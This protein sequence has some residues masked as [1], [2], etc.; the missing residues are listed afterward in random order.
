[1]KDRKHTIISREPQKKKKKKKK[2]LWLLHDKDAPKL[3]I[4]G[5][6]LIKGIYEKPTTNMTLNGKNWLFSPLDQ[7]EDKNVHPWALSWWVCYKRP[8]ALWDWLDVRVTR[9]AKNIVKFL[10]VLQ[11][12]PKNTAYRKYTE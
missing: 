5:N 6:L 8:S 10:N 3:G 1:M 2:S 12:I 11:Q 7:E 4:E 9:E